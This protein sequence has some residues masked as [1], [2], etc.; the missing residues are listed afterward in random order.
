MIIFLKVIF[1]GYRHITRVVS[2]FSAQKSEYGNFYLINLILKG[3][4][5]KC[6]K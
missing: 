6:K 1:K 3:G 5:H 4:T 2:F